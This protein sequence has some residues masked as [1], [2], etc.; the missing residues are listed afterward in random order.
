MQQVAW[1]PCASITLVAFTSYYGHSSPFATSRLVLGKGSV[2]WLVLLEQAA[3]LHDEGEHC[4]PQNVPFQS[5]EHAT[6][7][8]NLPIRHHLTCLAALRSEIVQLAAPPFQAV[9]IY[10]FMLLAIH[11]QCIAAGRPALQ[12]APLLPAGKV[13]LPADDSSIFTK[14]N[15]A[16]ML[17]RHATP[18]ERAI[19]FNTFSLSRD[20]NGE[21]A[22][23]SKS[24]QCLCAGNPEHQTDSQAVCAAKVPRA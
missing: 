7:L 1:L 5:T 14:K 11:A 6:L 2:A 21:M 12:W 17:Q 13:G 20:G 15:M 9:A 16:T 8:V 19:I 4:M 10:T 23:P 18:E 22:A 24:A 3:A